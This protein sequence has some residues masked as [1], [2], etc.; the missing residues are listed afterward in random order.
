MNLPPPTC[1]IKYIY[2]DDQIIIVDKPANLLSVPG[3]TPEG[4]DCLIHRVQQ[5]F[6]EARIVHRLDFSTSGLMVI[7]QNRESHRELS[8][9]FQDRETE[10]SYI[11]TVYGHPEEESG[12]VNLPLRC[13]WERRPIQIVDH[14]QGKNAQTFWR[15]DKRFENSCRVVLTPVTGRT[16]QL[17]VHMKA[18]GH[19][20]LGDEF[21]AHEAAF[22][23]ADRLCLHAKELI[24]THPTNNRR[25]TFSSDECF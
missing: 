16:H 8:R 3:K 14:K 10:K 6:P 1:D 5:R 25:M 20:I 11:A 19:P 17:R 21:Y 7:A 24:I 13:D 2:E 15:I 4:Q 23:M 18:I 22:E 12:N 9:Q